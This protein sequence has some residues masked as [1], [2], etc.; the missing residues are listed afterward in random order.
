M[1]TKVYR[2]GYQ[3]VEVRLPRYRGMVTQVYEYGYRGV[4]VWL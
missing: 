3:G 2:Y 4:G 1:A